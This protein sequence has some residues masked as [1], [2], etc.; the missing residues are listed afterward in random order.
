MK[1]ISKSHVRR[2]LGVVAATCWQEGVEPII[3]DARKRFLKESN[4]ALDF[5]IR[6]SCG[7]TKTQKREPYFL[8]QRFNVCKEWQRWCWLTC[9]FARNNGKKNVLYEKF[10]VLGIYC[11]CDL[12]AKPGDSQPSLY[13]WRLVAGNAFQIWSTVF[14]AWWIA[15]SWCWN[16]TRE[17]VQKEC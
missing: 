9:F 3:R 16:L 15:V 12:C 2:Y 1:H 10:Q 7:V 6:K 4:G 11:S 8:M 5:P 17:L 13:K 14:F